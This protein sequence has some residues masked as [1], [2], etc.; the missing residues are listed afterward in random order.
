[1]TQSKIVSSNQNTRERDY[2]LDRF[3]GELTR[4][5]FPYDFKPPGAYSPEKQRYT[6]RFSPDVARRIAGLSGGSDVKTLV[7]HATALTLLLRRYSGNRDV[8]FGIP[9]YRQDQEGDFLNTVLA[10]RNQVVDTAAFK[11]LLLAVGQS[12][13]ES[14]EHMNYSINSL[15]YNL[16][17]PSSETCFP[18][19]D[20]ALV[21][22]QLH[23]RSYLDQLKLNLVFN[24]SGNGDAAELEIEYNPACYK[25]TTVEQIAGHWEALLAGALEDVHGP[26]SRIEL[27]GEEEKKRLV[28]DL[29]DTEADFPAGK[30]LQELFEEQVE[31]AP[32][33]IALVFEDRQLTFEELNRATNRL[34]HYL[35]RQGVGP[36][37]TVG[38]LMERSVEMIVGLLG[39][40]KAGGAYLPID[41]A[42][43]DK[44]VAKMLDS[45][46][47]SLLLTQRGVIDHHDLTF[48][49]GLHRERGRVE[50]TAA[51][52]GSALEI[53]VLDELDDALA[54]QPSANPERPARPE[55]LAYVIFTSGS[56]G[57]PKGVM[58]AHKNATNTLSWFT[59]TARLGPHSKVMLTYDYTSDPSVE[60]I[61]ATLA[62]GAT[63]HVTD[64]Y[65]VIDRERFRDFAERHR[66]CILNFVP[67]IIQEHLADQ[68][69]LDCLDIVLPGG[70]RL[71]D[72]LKDDLIGRGYTVYND[73]GPTEASIDCLSSLCG[74][75]PVNLGHPIDN[76][77]CYVLDENLELLPPGVAG[78]LA[79]SGEGIA[80]GYLNQPAQTATHFVPN[81]FLVG[82][83]IYRTG[84]RA[85]R[86]ADGEV[87]FLGREDHQVKI[88][89]YRL[90]IGE[91]EHEIQSLEQVRETVVT[92]REDTRGEVVLCCYFVS[93]EG[94]TSSKL[95]QL[96]LSSLPEYVIPSFFV[97]MEKIP[98]THQG[99]TDFAALPDPFQ[100]GV[101]G[102]G[103][104][105]ETKYEKVV[106]QVWQ[107]VL[108]V[109]GVGVRD[110]F[111][112]IGG[113]S[114]NIIEVNR[115]LNQL[116]G[117]DIPVVEVFRFP[118]ISTFAQHLAKRLGE[119]PDSPAEKSSSPDWIERQV[120][121]MEET[122]QMFD[123]FP[124]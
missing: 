3:S 116:L 95:R 74:E 1:M 103:S 24:L 119:T 48:L 115:K 99:K 37:V 30:T 94:L 17:L 51:H 47:T 65:M 108:G 107:E 10:L 69:K 86:L 49:Q 123:N 63:L 59:K 60:D 83:R 78:E 118:T 31:K 57:T 4:S 110:N 50:V 106:L 29:N 100:H 44:R 42:M 117:T 88:R 105:P 27:L 93:E 35:G 12:L 62:C 111:F 20:V 92:T 46:G 43:P 80:R 18:L 28:F 68:P 75:D 21:S 19:F 11:D 33:E 89:G 58:L 2:W 64:P 52:Q 114:L 67:R 32:D 13:F 113:H 5:H 55:N 109:T 26:V 39:I 61:F 66:I 77:A 85:R 121:V 87:E 79:V 40:L 16:S 15:V 120:G 25:Q 14:N 38:V 91:V 102:Q 7:L 41:P 71:D 23:E 53:L 6:L 36:E 124:S 84:D 98:L 22:R 82:E 90:E 112:D 72:S 97:R 81:P 54:R 45:A 8:V 101:D 73:Y 76:M 96:L 70:E 104:Q 122:V 9:I 56:T 34:A